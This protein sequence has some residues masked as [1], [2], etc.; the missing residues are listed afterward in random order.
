[1]ERREEASAGDSW[2]LVAEDSDPET[3][4]R[5]QKRDGG[6]SSHVYYEVTVRW[7]IPR[8]A[9]EGL[10]RISH[11]AASWH[12]KWAFGKGAAVPYNGTSNVFKVQRPPR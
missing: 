12:K 9:P 3:Q 11:H 6:L 1:M 2:V 5:V 7:A 4:I 10:Y 8:D